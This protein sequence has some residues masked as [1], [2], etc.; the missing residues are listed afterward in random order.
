[1]KIFLG[2]PCGGSIV[3]ST[4]LCLTGAVMA[5]TKLMHRFNFWQ[6]TYCDR[7]HNAIVEHALEVGSD[8]VM[9]IDSDQEFPLD[10]INRLVAHGKDIVGCAYRMRQH[11]F[12]LM[13]D[14]TGVGLKPVEWLP[15]GVMLVRRRVFE[16]IPFPWFPNISGKSVGEFVGSDRVFCR[17]AAAKG[18]KIFCD[19]DLSRQVTH[20]ASV[21]LAFD[22]SIQSP[23]SVT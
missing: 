7:A 12:P 14:G 19:Y 9:F 6:D 3:P 15:S 13:P 22:G 1:M 16:E 10:T 18:F 5:S 21:A 20:I 8:A 17:K 4:A 2:T 11:P 23:G